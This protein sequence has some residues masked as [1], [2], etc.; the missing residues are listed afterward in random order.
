MRDLK[1][2]LCF[3]GQPRAWQVALP[4]IKQFIA[5]FDETPD[6][7]CHLWNFNSTSNHVVGATKGEVEQDE[8]V[9][10][11]EVNDLIQH[12]QPKKLIIEDRNKSD[13]IKRRALNKMND[14]VGLDK[15]LNMGGCPFWLAPQYYSMKRASEL[16]SE[17][18][19]ENK[20]FYDVV[21]RMRYDLFLHDWTIN[22]F[23]KLNNNISID[24][25]DFYGT[26][27]RAINEF[28]F[29][30]IG[31]VFFWADSHTY[32]T[33]AEYVNFLP[34]VFAKNFPKDLSPEKLFAYFIRSSFLN[35]HSFELDPKVARS[36]EYFDLLKQNG[37]EPYLCDIGAHDKLYIHK[38]LV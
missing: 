5:E 12:Y 6:I 36:Q 18:E 10:Q 20:F 25:F 11:T 17:Y 35:F 23:F 37:H 9:R 26:H 32:S 34:H 31:D 29:S 14:L 4:S 22:D 21:I 15:V 1:V 7:F 16:K 2:A 38:N 13:A 8:I 24:P 19:V 33:V 27:I 3:S 30:I 28:P